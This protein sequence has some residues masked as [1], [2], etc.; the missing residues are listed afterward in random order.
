VKEKKNFENLPHIKDNIGIGHRIAR[1]DTG[2]HRLITVDN[3]MFLPLWTHIRLLV[4]SSDVIHSWAVP[5]FGIKIDATPGRLTQGSL[6]LKRTGNFWGQCSE[7]CGVNHAFMPVG[8][9]VCTSKSYNTQ[10]YAWLYW[11][12]FASRRFKIIT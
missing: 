10:I 8:V 4:T 3:T 1:V 6:F 11:D 5:A 12:E 7:I 9:V 2:E